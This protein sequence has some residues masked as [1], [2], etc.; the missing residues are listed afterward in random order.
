MKII[1]SRANQKANSRIWKALIHS[2]SLMGLEGKNVCPVFQGVT[3]IYILTNQN[4][5]TL[6]VGGV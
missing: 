3:Y 5:F 6:L 2:E 1:Q 4:V